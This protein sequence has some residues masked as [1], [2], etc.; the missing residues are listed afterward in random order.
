MGAF[1]TGFG[2]GMQ[3]WNNAEQ[4]RDRQ[5]AR[6][7]QDKLD[8]IAIDAAERKA[9]LDNI[10]LQELEQKRADE[11]G[12]RAAGS[13]LVG[14]DGFASG[15]QGQRIF[16]A[17]KSVAEATA[18]INAAV[19]ELSGQPA[20]PASEV[21]PAM[22]VT[23]GGQAPTI[24]A[25]GMK[26]DNS[27][28][29]RVQRQAEYLTKIGQGERAMKLQAEFK[30]FE[31]KLY[32]ANRT[33]LF[34]NFSSALYNKGPEEAVRM[35]DAYNDGITAKYVPSADGIGGTI[36]RY[37]DGTDTEVDRIN[38]KSADDLALQVKRAI[39]P[40]QYLAAQEKA[41]S[42]TVTV[43]PGEEIYQGGKLKYKNNTPTS[44]EASLARALMAG[45]GF[46]GAGGSGGTGGARGGKPSETLNN[47]ITSIIAE[48]SKDADSAMRLSPDQMT[49]ARAYGSM[50]ANNNPSID[51][52]VAAD[53]AMKV[54]RDPTLIKPSISSSGRIV[55][56]YV[57]QDGKP[58]PVGDLDLSRLSPEA[59]QDLGKQAERL[60]LDISQ[61]DAETAKQF[62]RLAHGDR[63]VKQQMKDEFVP[64]QI[65]A[66]LKQQPE[67]SREQATD[68]ALKI[69]DN[70]IS[71]NS[72]ALA[73]VRQLVPAPKERPT[74]FQPNRPS[75]PS[76]QRP[77]SPVFSA[78]PGSSPALTP[79]PV[80]SIPAGSG[81]VTVT[82]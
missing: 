53:I 81:P 70:M 9:K 29:A 55:G 60:L 2:F 27:L 22:G 54:T 13:D 82:R 65:D 79:S 37:K 56:T 8:K 43:K 49:Q 36:I 21:Q 73:T 6:E 77:G 68:M 10:T 5:L 35:Y 38:F 47:Q 74:R 18:E 11:Q 17:D 51:P 33:A 41:A 32:D 52:N 58:I 3:A 69:F 28:G 61:G 59:R 76:Q 15:E 71:N 39:F 23:G 12:L 62:L 57:G 75:Q 4:A 63:S 78:I 7:R 19:N 48:S 40:E 31:S 26:L 46:G 34:N 1:Q 42:E 66:I 64:A 16:S 24:A 45:S 50:L 80:S 72:G 25:P 44:G 14:Q 67:L 20:A 30:D